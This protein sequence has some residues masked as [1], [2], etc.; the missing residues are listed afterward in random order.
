MNYS[1]LALVLTCLL[2][3]TALAL[4]SDQVFVTVDVNES[5]P[6]VTFTWDEQTDGVDIQVSRRE[7]GQVGPAAWNP[8]ATIAHPNVSYT[9]SSLQSGIAYEYKV[10][11]EYVSGDISWAAS[12]IAVGVA[13][14]LVET[15]GR[16][17]LLVEAGMGQALAPELA[18]LEMDLVGD[19]WEVIRKDL[20][21]DGDL[22][23]DSVRACCCPA[24]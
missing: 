12:Y 18:E 9:D 7:I 23:P 16:M 21:R 19:G 17:L 3:V 13:A 4:D 20:P 24:D 6:S 5:A 10:Y 15:R 1:F 2:P 11:R 22:H 14:E 8:L